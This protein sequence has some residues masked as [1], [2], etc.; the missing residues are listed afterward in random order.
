[1]KIRP[2]FRDGDGRPGNRST[3][4]ISYAAGDLAGGRLRPRGQHADHVGAREDEAD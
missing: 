4:L 2:H 3:S 1:M